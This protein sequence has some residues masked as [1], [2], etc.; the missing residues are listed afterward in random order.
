[1]YNYHQ[2]EKQKDLLTRLRNKPN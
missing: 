2:F 1:M